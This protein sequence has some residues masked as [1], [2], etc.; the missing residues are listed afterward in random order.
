MP[1][2][3]LLFQKVNAAGV[4][5]SLTYTLIVVGTGVR[6]LFTT[7]EAIDSVPAAGSSSSVN[8][9]VAILGTAAPAFYCHNLS[10]LIVQRAEHPRRNIRNSS[11]AYFCAFLMMALVGSFG[12][13]TLNVESPSTMS[14][15]HLD[16]TAESLTLRIL[17]TC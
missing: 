12:S 1:K 5:F 6:A 7:Q 15:D 13:L 3:H 2:S 9:Y 14:T 4:F 10:L 16:L 11:T 17:L 8:A